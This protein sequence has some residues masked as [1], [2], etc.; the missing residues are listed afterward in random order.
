ML[1]AAVV[2][3]L[4]ASVLTASAR[5]A[6]TGDDIPPPTPS[7]VKAEPRDNGV[8]V[9]W[10]PVVDEGGS[11]LAE[12]QVWRDGRWYGWV[13]AGTTTFRDRDAGA[14]YYQIRAVDNAGNRS[15]WSL[16]AQVTTG[17]D[18]TPPPTPTEVSAG[19]DGSRVVL[20]WTAVTDEGGSGLREYEIWRDGRWY[21]WV[22]AS[23]TR[24]VDDT[25]SNGAYYQVRAV[26][27]ARNTS[28]WS[29]RVYPPTGPDLTPPPTPQGLIAMRQ[30]DGTVV[31]EW[32]AV[33]DEGGSGLR[34]YA[35]YRDGR[36]YG[37]VWAST[38][39]F[40]DEDP[41]TGAQYQV[42]A[43]DWAL[44]RSPLSAKVTAAAPG[45]CVVAE[46]VVDTTLS[47]AE[48]SALV[49]LYESTTGESW[50][51]N[52]GWLTPTDP[53]TWYG[54]TCWN[55]R[56]TE[57]RLTANRIDGPLPP[58]IGDLHAL[59]VLDFT[60]NNRL[61]G[62]LPVELSRLTSLQWLTMT[63]TSIGGE[64]P[65]WL[66]EMRSL[67]S[68]VLRAAKLSGPIPPEL[69][70]MSGL[71]HLVLS[72]NELSGSLPPELGSMESLVTFDVSLNSLSGSIPPELGNL[73]QLS[74]LSLAGNDLTG[75]IPA[76]F[77]QLTR[78]LDLRVD[79]NRLT[80]DVTGALAAHA[81]DLVVARLGDGGGGNDCFT[82]TDVVLAESLSRLDPGWDA[83][84][85]P[86]CV[87]SGELVRTAASQIECDALA[88][89]YESTG[90]DAWT[91]N[92]GWLTPTNPCEWYGVTCSDAGV[93]ALGLGL[94]NLSGPV[95]A[96]LGQ[97]VEL[98]VLNLNL[99]A[100]SGP[101][102]AELANLSKLRSLQMFGAPLNSPFPTWIGEL[103][104]LD[105]LVLLH[106]GLSGEIPPGIG[107]L[108]NLRVLALNFNELSGEIPREIGN[109]VNLDSL[110][111]AYNRLSGEIPP[112]IGNLTGLEILF[113]QN[114]LLV[115]TLPDEL[116]NVPLQS[117]TINDNQLTG[118]VTIPL[119]GIGN[120]INS[121]KLSDGPGGNDC[122]TTTDADLAAI[123]AV[124]DP[125]WDECEA[126]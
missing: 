89:I 81:G 10:N 53:C 110:Q 115:G 62:P 106:T 6:E 126:A 21:D 35:I 43:I 27:N 47:G 67:H 117:F 74:S 103:A 111:L 125:T 9:S 38:T 58:E 93:T 87:I 15:G 94:N 28:G 83:C 64:I 63:S 23:E 17:T 82:S 59:R 39:R 8:E 107:D 31:L 54:I 11:G 48:C 25:P 92:T 84:E 61:I 121:V 120:V 91:N 18:T 78:L 105:T 44:N 30:Q 16:R 85:P 13:A 95:P 51:R 26:D 90:G 100:L 112:E 123:L 19:V 72:Y 46:R 45:A 3:A 41:V 20:T 71:H 34:E 1:A 5:A 86:S 116:A 104:A 42:R 70:S 80:G 99:N 65:P 76:A 14:G 75:T 55:G 66:G 36:W 109:L 88:A 40:V 122:F 98:E 96:E 97:L 57:I 22:R 52:S 49:A 29:E 77:S 79:N 118:D 33:T 50:F 113:V 114:N 124:K 4:I 37:W 60:N 12:Y 69:A 119:S 7:G 101:P 24:Y 73:S 108:T 68:L 32:G 2:A 102:P 56:L